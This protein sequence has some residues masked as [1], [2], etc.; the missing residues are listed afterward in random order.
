MESFQSAIKKILVAL[1]TMGIREKQGANVQ[2]YIVNLILTVLKDP[3][4]TKRL[5]NNE[6]D[7][8]I[9]EIKDL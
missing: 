7:K 5:Q 6:L 1:N 8:I 2:N 3:E 9:Q 4:L